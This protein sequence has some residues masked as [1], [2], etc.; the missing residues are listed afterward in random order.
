MAKKGSKPTKINNKPVAKPEMLPKMEKV[1]PIK[2]G[3]KC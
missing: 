1:F 3:K 2:K